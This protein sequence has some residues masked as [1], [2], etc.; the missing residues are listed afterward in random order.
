M[1]RV[2]AKA[3]IR[4]SLH[5]HPDF[6]FTPLQERNQARFSETRACLLASSKQASE[7]LAAAGEARATGVA[8]IVLP[9]PVLPCLLSVSRSLS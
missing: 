8:S 3:H 4:M 5:P 1:M 2:T 7:Q 6:A 9:S